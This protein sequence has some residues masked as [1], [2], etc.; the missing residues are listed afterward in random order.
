M[1]YRVLV[2]GGS[3]GIGRAIVEELSGRD[4]WEII[5][6]GRSELDLD[7]MVSVEK[8]VSTLEPVNA[9]VNTAGLNILK[10]LE[11]I[12]DDSLQSMLNIN[13][14][15]PLKLIQAVAGGMKKLHGGRILSFSS[16]WGMRSKE[17]RTMYSIGKFG[18]RGVT[19][20]LAR[21]LGP[22]NILVNAIAPGYVLTDMTRQNVP[23]DEMADICRQIPLRRMAEV[24]EIAKI[25]AFLISPDNSYITGQ[26]IVADGGFLA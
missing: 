24:H 23:A 19:A 14:I 6:P 13:L 5:A 17:L 8:F 12:D 25:A 3:R 4:G 1:S 2:T 18:I 10:S 21:E 20:A 11:D 26:T 22:D 9:L 7:D 15:S 16:I